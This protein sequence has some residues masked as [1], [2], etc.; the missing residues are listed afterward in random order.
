MVRSAFAALFWF[1]EH[2]KHVDLGNQLRQQFDALGRQL[3]E[4]D[5]EAGEVAAGPGETGDQPLYH[6]IVAARIS[7]GSL[8]LNV[9]TFSR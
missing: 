1:H 4:E 5:A 6:R 3:G 8:G 9:P 7:I 2:S